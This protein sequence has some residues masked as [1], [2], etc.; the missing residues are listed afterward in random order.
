MKDNENSLGQKEHIRSKSPINKRRRI[1]NENPF[2][3]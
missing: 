1:L 3:I 2:D